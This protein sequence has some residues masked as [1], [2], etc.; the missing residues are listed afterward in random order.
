MLLRSGHGLA[1]K[2][3]GV[4]IDEPVVLGDVTISVPAIS[5][6]VQIPMPTVSITARVLWTIAV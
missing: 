5:M 1:G 2:T 3:R 6:V 4:S